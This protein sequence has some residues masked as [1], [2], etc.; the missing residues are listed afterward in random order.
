MAEEN[1]ER[2]RALLEAWNA[3]GDIQAWMRASAEGDAD[4]SIFDPY[5]VYED[6]NLPDHV[7]EAYHGL[8]GVMRA[9]ER[10]LEPFESLSVELQEIVGSGDRLVSIHQTQARARHSGIE[11]EG[12]LFYAWTFRDGKIV[13]FQSFRERDEA[14]AAAGL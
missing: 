3:G 6:A 1:V 5:V 12:P 14:L 4:N 8:D 9:A 7:G 10:W 2:L 11:I 13:H